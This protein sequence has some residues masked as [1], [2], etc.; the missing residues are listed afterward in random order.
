MKRDLVFQEG[1]ILTNSKQK[2]M[3]LNANHMSNGK[4][5]VLS[6]IQTLCFA[7]NILFGHVFFSIYEAKGFFVFNL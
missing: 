3:P 6:T 2:H 5:M 4:Q 1:I 7:V